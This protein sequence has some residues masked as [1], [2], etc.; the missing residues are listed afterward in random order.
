MENVLEPVYFFDGFWFFSILDVR[1]G[2]YN[3]KAD[4]GKMMKQYQERIDLQNRVEY[5]KKD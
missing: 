5:S 2:P 1:F 4:A 3:A